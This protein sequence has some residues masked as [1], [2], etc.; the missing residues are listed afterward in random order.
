MEKIFGVSVTA[1]S[2]LQMVSCGNGRNITG[3]SSANGLGIAG[4]LEQKV[5]AV[6]T[7]FPCA[8]G[9]KHTLTVLRF[10]SIGPGAV[11]TRI[12][13]S[14]LNES[15]AVQVS[16]GINSERSVAVVKNYGHA[17]DVYFYLCPATYWNNTGSNSN[18]NMFVQSATLESPVETISVNQRCYF[19]QILV[20]RTTLFIA[21]GVPM[22]YAF[23]PVDQLGSVPGV[24]ESGY[25]N[26][27]GNG[28]F[29]DGY[30]NGYYNG[31]YYS[32]F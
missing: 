22:P 2:L 19:N 28:G 6:Q 14:A 32:G 15:N 31:G 5:R 21:G 13:A 25:G 17:M 27:Y 9:G 18:N 12:G 20:L 16:I 24:C 8:N 30:N 11:A 29:N 1:M 7:T 3:S 23:F 10:S 26:G 4:T